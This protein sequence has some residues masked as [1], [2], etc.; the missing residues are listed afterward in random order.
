MIAR[1]QISELVFHGFR[2]RA[3]RFAR[4]P[5][6][7]RLA[8]AQSQRIIAGHTHE[9]TDR[10][11]YRVK[12]KRKHN[13]TCNPGQQQS[14]FLPGPIKR[15]KRPASQQREREKAR[16]NGKRPPAHR[17]RRSM[18]NRQHRDQCKKSRYDE[19]ERTIR[20]TLYLRRAA[21]ILM[22]FGTFREMPCRKAQML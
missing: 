21:E 13:G 3:R 11:H 18:Q 4:D 6:A 14:E 5:I 12:Q 15:T 16:R 1:S 8:S 9:Q 22:H 19:T 2:C 17:R 7:Y 20:R 10:G